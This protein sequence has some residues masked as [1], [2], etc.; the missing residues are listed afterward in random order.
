MQDDVT[1]EFLRDAIAFLE[2]TPED[3]VPAT[4]YVKRSSEYKIN[5]IKSGKIGWY[6][7]E[8][9]DRDAAK[10]WMTMKAIGRFIAPW[11]KT[12]AL[13]FEEYRFQ[14]D[15]FLA[16]QSERLIYHNEGDAQYLAKKIDA[17]DNENSNRFLYGD[18]CR[19]L[20]VIPAFLYM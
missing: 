16:E 8:A 2:K 3:R 4:E 18:S 20:P 6:D 17:L 11:E 19:G 5:R 15:S 14:T 10:F 12:R 1:P 7:G 9:A 13:W